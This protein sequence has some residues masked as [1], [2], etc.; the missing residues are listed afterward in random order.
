MNLK[1]VTAGLLALG[2]AG[3]SS[4]LAQA[5]PELKSDDDKAFYALGLFISRNVGVFNLTPA[6]LEI[7]KSGLS[8]GVTGKTPKVELETWGPKLQMLAQSR[9]KETAEKEKKTGEAFA[10]MA[11]AEPGAR[12]LAGGTI[13]KEIKPGTGAQPKATDTVKVHYE[14]KLIDGT[15]FDSSVKRG[16]PAEFALNRV[17]KC[18]TEGVQE[19]KTGGKAKLVCPADIAYGDAGSPPNIKP[20]AT[21]TF[22]VELLEV[23]PAEAA[24]VKPATAPAPAATDKPA[25]K[26]A[27]APKKN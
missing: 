11:A 13:I 25:A 9:A 10:A 18:W 24:A 14:G 16:E 17:I 1:T 7:V 20:G 22:E 3:S 27:P 8:D 21:L 15:I 5:A 6:E 19:M 2:L 23:K 26:P 12:K 4:L